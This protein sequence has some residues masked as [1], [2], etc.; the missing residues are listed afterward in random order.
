MTPEFLQTVKDI[1]LPVLTAAGTWFGLRLSSRK[2]K[3]DDAQALFNEVQEERGEL[4]KERAEL[5]TEM[6]LLRGEVAQL[7][8]ENMAMRDYVQELRN[9]IRMGTPPPPR[10]W[11]EGLAGG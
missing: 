2:N 10:P 6:G 8:A 9:D 1:A 3:S 4:K 7:R 11:P 5:K